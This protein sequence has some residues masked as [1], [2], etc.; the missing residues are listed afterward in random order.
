[1]TD[2]PSFGSVII[3]N[4][5]LLACGLLLS[6]QSAIAEGLP[7]ADGRYAGGEVLTLTLDEGQKGFIENLRNCHLEGEWETPTNTSPTCST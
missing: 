6:T 5:L 3:A 2:F 1:M 7:I 4:R